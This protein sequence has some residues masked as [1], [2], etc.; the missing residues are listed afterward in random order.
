MKPELIA[1]LSL[2][3]L[4]L[5]QLAW[6]AWLTPPQVI[7]LW[8]ALLLA[9]GPL[10]LPLIGLLLRS[11]NALFLA[12]TLAL[13]YFSHGVMEAWANP[14]VRALALTEMLLS[15]MLIGFAGWPSWRDGMARRR[16]KRAA[17]A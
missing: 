1:K 5:L 12:A 13:L 11:P 2:L 4:L 14:A 17:Q 3:G 15:L 6:Y 7:P 8:L 9:A 16:A 10:L